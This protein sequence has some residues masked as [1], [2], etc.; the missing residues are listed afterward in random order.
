[1]LIQ[2]ASRGLEYINLAG[3]ICGG[4]V[5]RL[6]IFE[7]SLPYIALPLCALLLHTGLSYLCFDALFL[8]TLKSIS[9]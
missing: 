2:D 9:A 5:D 6:P 7:L 3:E 8:Y 4:V 1:M